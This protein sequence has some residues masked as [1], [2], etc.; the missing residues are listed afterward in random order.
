MIVSGL[1]IKSLIVLS[2]WQ[3]GNLHIVLIKYHFTQGGN[4]HH[5]FYPSSQLAIIKTL[6]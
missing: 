6:Y 4:R 3:D 1:L 2:R 5:P